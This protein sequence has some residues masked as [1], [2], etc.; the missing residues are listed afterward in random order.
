MCI[1]WRECCWHA[2]NLHI[3][4]KRVLATWPICRRKAICRRYT[5]VYQKHRSQIFLD[6]VHSHLEL[7]RQDIF[8]D[9]YTDQQYYVILH[10]SHIYCFGINRNYVGQLEEIHETIQS[11]DH[12]GNWRRWKRLGARETKMQFLVIRG[13]LLSKARNHK[14]YS[15]FLK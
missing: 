9:A 1:S 6:D 4:I 12:G 7:M 13:Y 14:S 5:Y 2:H 11:G 3:F 15:A 8:T 10:C